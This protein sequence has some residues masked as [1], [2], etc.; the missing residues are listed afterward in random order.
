MHTKP[1]KRQT[2]RKFVEGGSF[3][4]IVKCS[5]LNM[6]LQKLKRALKDILLF[7]QI[8][9]YFPSIYVV[10]STLEQSDGRES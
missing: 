8:I 1:V 9:T 3:M 2:A 10:P 6:V 7:L 5:F 4:F